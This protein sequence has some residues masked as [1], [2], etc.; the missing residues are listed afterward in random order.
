MGGGWEFLWSR[1]LQQHTRQGASHWGRCGLQAQRE[2]SSAG[3]HPQPSAGLHHHTGDSPHSVNRELWPYLIIVTWSV[4][5]WAASPTAFR[6]VMG[7][8]SYSAKHVWPLADNQIHV[9]LCVMTEFIILS[10]QLVQH[11]VEWH[12]LA[13]VSN[14]VPQNCIMQGQDTSEFLSYECIKGV[15]LV[16][17]MLMYVDGLTCQEES[18]ILSIRPAVLWASLGHWDHQQLRWDSLWWDC[19]ITTGN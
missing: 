11:T 17:C 16:V 19:T 3:S 18:S 13:N 6:R 10:M 7:S 1:L 5:M 8:A 9:E 15:V 4:C 14:R 12:H 2:W